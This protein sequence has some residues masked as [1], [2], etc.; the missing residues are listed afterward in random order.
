MIM[1]RGIFAIA[2]GLMVAG[3]GASPHRD[4]AGAQDGA[5][6]NP[7]WRK[8][9]FPPRDAIQPAPERPATAAEKAAF[10]EKVNRVCPAGTEANPFPQLSL[11]ARAIKPSWHG[12][13]RSLPLL[14]Q[15]IDALKK[16]LAA[17]PLDNPDR[18]KIIDRLASTYFEL[19]RALY[20]TCTDLVLMAETDRYS[21][22]KLEEMLGDLKRKIDAARNGGFAS[23]RQLVQDHPTYQST[24]L[25]ATPDNSVPD[26]L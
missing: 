14:P 7:E 9:V 3:C 12:R 5:E 11:P 19:E 22:S 16:I 17:T 10:V 25:C 21:M 24:G 18:P 15:E 23:C 1:R 6:G 4:P 20:R 8:G 26:Y 13:Y 2:L